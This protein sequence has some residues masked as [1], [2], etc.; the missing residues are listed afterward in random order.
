MW[1]ESLCSTFVDYEHFV[2]EF[3]GRFESCGADIVT[4]EE[5]FLNA[6]QR[7]TDTVSAFYTY[8]LKLQSQINSLGGNITQS[9][10]F[11]RFLYGLQ[12]TLLDKVRPHVMVWKPADKTVNNLKSLAESFAVKPKPAGPDLCLVDPRRKRS[13]FKSSCWFCRSK[14]H[15]ADDCPKIAARKAAGTWEERPFKGKQ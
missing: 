7:S 2:S 10:L 14:E 11:S 9:Q 8:L 6:R 12:P 4:L 5:R 1:F 3:K 13:T 15:V